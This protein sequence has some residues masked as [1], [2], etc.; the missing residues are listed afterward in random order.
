MTRALTVVKGA[1]IYTRIEA[2]EARKVL[3]IDDMIEL[4]TH[5]EGLIFDVL[6][7]FIDK[8]TCANPPD[9]E[10]GRNMC[11]EAVSVHASH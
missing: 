10:P 3:E 7:D 4:E 9:F 11:P 6:D 2:D 5:V 8:G 1:P